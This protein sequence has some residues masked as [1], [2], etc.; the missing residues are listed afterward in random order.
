MSELGKS[1]GLGRFL[2]A[3]NHKQMS[4]SMYKAQ[5]SEQVV[6]KAGLGDIPEISGREG[7]DLA[8]P[9]H[10]EMAHEE[11]GES[12]RQTRKAVSGSHWAPST[13]TAAGHA[14]AED[15]HESA[16]D[17]HARAAD[18]HRTAQ[19][20]APTAEKAQYHDRMATAHEHFARAHHA[21]EMLHN[22]AGDR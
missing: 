22:D 4:E 13:L 5:V 15:L 8:H 20:S 2:Q 18:W 14:M 3:C 7:S 19:K 6:E 12:F 9:R 1:F 10:A 16:G 11:T 21:L 17:S